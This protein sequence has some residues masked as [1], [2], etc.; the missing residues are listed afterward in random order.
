MSEQDSNTSAEPPRGG[1]VEARQSDDGSFELVVDD[2]PQ[3]G[4]DAAETVS[5]L[6]SSAEG[7]GGRTRRLAVGV[8]AALA[9]LGLAWGLFA[10]GD[11]SSKDAEEEEE[12]DEE[13]EEGFK[14]Y[15]GSPGGGESGKRQRARTGEAEQGRGDDESDKERR[16]ARS[17]NQ[18][19]D[20]AEAKRRA[21]EEGDEKDWELEKEQERIMEQEAAREASREED[22]RD[23]ED[24]DAEDETDEEDGGDGDEAAVAPDKIEDIR[25]KLEQPVDQPQF[26]N[27]LSN[28]QAERFDKLREEGAFDQEEPRD[29]EEAEEMLDEYD[30][31]GEHP[32]GARRE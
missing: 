4:S 29:V 18:R 1:D 25:G 22:R 16:E 12:A 30:E 5:G 10:G 2:K 17:Q 20:P 13:V 6:A 14:P 26:R 7:T 27:E 19:G 3:G 15:S 32:N 9:A 28:E 8:V 21:D 23:D 11:D 31:E 24:R